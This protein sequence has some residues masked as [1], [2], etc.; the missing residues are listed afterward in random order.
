MEGVGDGRH[1]TPT[2]PQTMGDEGFE[3]PLNG[4]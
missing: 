1:V 3:P 2:Q 4:L